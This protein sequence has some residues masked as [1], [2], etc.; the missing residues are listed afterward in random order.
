MVFVLVFGAVAAPIGVIVMVN[1]GQQRVQ[2]EINCTT[3][4]AGLI[5]ARLIQANRVMLVRIAHN[6]G[7]PVRVPPPIS[8]PEVPVECEQP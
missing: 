4:R 3:L 5:E 8:L 1:E 2:F 7:L 6:L